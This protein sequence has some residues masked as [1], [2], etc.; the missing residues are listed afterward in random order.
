MGF[1]P[2]PCVLSNLVFSAFWLPKGSSLYSRVAVQLTQGY[3][4]GDS[5]KTP[6]FC[7]AA[8]DKEDLL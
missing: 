5:W 1:S 6:H 8:R 3:L 7:V 4:P 2:Q